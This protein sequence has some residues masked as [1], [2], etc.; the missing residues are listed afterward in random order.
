MIFFQ[1]DGELTK[2]ITAGALAAVEECR[3]Q[4][5]NDLWDCPKDAFNRDPHVSTPI[6]NNDTLLINNSKTKFK[7]RARRQQFSEQRYV[8]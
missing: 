2:S 7:R 5:R 6:F 4:F 8:F 1:A 3:H